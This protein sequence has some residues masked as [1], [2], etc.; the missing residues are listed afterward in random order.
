MNKSPLSRREPTWCRTEGILALQSSFLAICVKAE[1]EGAGCPA[2]LVIRVQPTNSCTGLTA[3]VGRT[4]QEAP[5]RDS[6]M[7]QGSSGQ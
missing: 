7:K 1:L 6:E 3:G 4:G 2:Q 5:S